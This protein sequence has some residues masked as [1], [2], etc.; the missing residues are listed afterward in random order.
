[1]PVYHAFGQE[2]VSRTEFLTRAAEIE[3]SVSFDVGTVAAGRCCPS[4]RQ[5]RVRQAAEYPDPPCLHWPLSGEEDVRLAQADAD[6]IGDQGHLDHFGCGAS[7]Q[8]A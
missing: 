2:L 6:H 5:Y 3:Q 7:H 1:M 8:C 4:L